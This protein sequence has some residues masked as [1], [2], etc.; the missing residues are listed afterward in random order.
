MKTHFVRMIDRND[1]YFVVTCIYC[2]T[3]QEKAANRR[4]P[5]SLHR[6]SMNVYIHSSEGKHWGCVSTLAIWSFAMT[7]ANAVLAFCTNSHRENVEGNVCKCSQV[8]RAS[9]QQ[10]Q[11]IGALV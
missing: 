3:S 11:I 10:M 7:G 4:P 9:E 6:L 1:L 5:S 2:M 8:D